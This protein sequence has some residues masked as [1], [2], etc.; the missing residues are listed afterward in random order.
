MKKTSLIALAGVL[1]AGASYA[2]FQPSA[3]KNAG[4]F[5]DSAENI[6]TVKQVMEMRDEVPVVVKGK[7]LKRLGD[8]KYLFEDSTGTINVEIDKDDWRG[9][10]V[11]PEDT[12]KL[13]G[14]VDSG[15][16]KTEIDVD[17]VEKVAVPVVQAQ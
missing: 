2:D 12:V 7:I 3:V 17:Y 13:I 1:M 8:D 15:L 11:G 6:V 14:E 10:T 9:I 5:V 16:F 4:G